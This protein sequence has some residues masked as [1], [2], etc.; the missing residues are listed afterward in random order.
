MAVPESQVEVTFRRRC[1][2]TKW[3]Y[4]RF[5]L[6]RELCR[7]LPRVSLSGYFGALWIRD[8]I[9]TVLRR[10]R[11][12]VDRWCE[13]VLL[14]LKDFHGD[15]VETVLRRWTSFHV[16]HFVALPKAP[17]PA[18]AGLKTCFDNQTQHF[19]ALP[20]TPLPSARWSTNLPTSSSKVQR[21]VWANCCI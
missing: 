10:S 1:R 9:Q 16:L 7:F 3:G 21:I 2:G 14:Q 19:S 5:G 17:Y 12:L 18:V 11:V 6:G 13:T 4:A 20:K 8:A 15:L